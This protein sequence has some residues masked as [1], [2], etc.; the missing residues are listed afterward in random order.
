MRVGTFEGVVSDF[1]RLC[2][3][4]VVLISTQILLYRVGNAKIDYQC[5]LFTGILG[6]RI[7]WLSEIPCVKERSADNEFELTVD[8]A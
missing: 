1:D 2:S 4:F 8:T 6:V 7:F 5:S 3:C